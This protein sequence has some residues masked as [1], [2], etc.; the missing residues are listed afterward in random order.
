[1]PSV[2]RSAADP[3][4]SPAAAPAG[5]RVAAVTWSLVETLV[6]LG[7]EPVAVADRRGYSK[8]VAHPPLPRDSVDVGRRIEPNLTVLAGTRPD[9][10]VMSG[11]YA[12]LVRTLERIAP[13]VTLD[14]YVP[15][16]RPLDLARE[17]TDCL[18]LRFS[19][20]ADAARLVGRLETATGSLAQAARRSSPPGPAY[21]VAFRDAD[22]VRVYGENSLFGEVLARAGIDNAWRGKTNFWG[23]ASVEFTRLDEQAAHMVVIGPVPLDAAEMM[24]ESPI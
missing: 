11:L 8:W 7:V 6:A 23:F 22:H 5:Q 9:V 2:A 17:V 12:E 16:G 21:I 14:I 13:V 20:Q 1:M 18:A 24:D 15:R 3:C 19:R 10:I 4:E